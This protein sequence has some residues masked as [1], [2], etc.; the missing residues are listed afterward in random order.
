MEHIS[1]D[2]VLEGEFPHENGAGFTQGGW[3]A[4]YRTPAGLAAVIKAQGSPFDLLLGRRTYD[5]WSTFWPKAGN[6]PAANGINAA[7]KY[8]A[9]HRPDSLKWGP[10]GDLGADILEGIHSLKSTDGPDLI[11][12]GSSTLASM[13]LEQRLVDEIVLIVYPVLR[14]RGKHLFS[15]SANPRE[16]TFVSTKV[17][18]TGVLINTY[19][20]VG[21]VSKSMN[22]VKL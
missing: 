13:L 8:V 21:I 3:T 9:T 6:S 5:A 1:L 18:P 22:P 12:W 16:F 10:L 2:G 15:D 17:S 7:T 4:P 20:P 19:R 11:V 14:G